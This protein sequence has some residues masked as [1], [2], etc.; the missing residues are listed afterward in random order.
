MQ[1][2]CRLSPNMARNSCKRV[3]ICFRLDSQSVA[4]RTPLRDETMGG[5]REG[6]TGSGGIPN[7]LGTHREPITMRSPLRAGT[8]CVL[9]EKANPRGAFIA[10]RRIKQ[11]KR[12]ISLE[13]QQADAWRAAPRSPNGATPPRALLTA[14]ERWTPK[15]QRR[16]C[17]PVAGHRA[18]RLV[19][20]RTAANAL[21]QNRGVRLKSTPSA[22]TFRGVKRSMRSMRAVHQS[23]SSLRTALTRAAVMHSGD[24]NFKTC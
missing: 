2:L 12:Q 8:D 17:E 16:N 4:E 14:L 15:L 1:S 19:S 3:S 9:C 7:E 24:R 20:A 5:L 23:S 11:S 21:S 6:L 18:R 22:I 13:P 10:V